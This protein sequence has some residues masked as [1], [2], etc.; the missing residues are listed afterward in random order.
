MPPPCAFGC[1]S[2]GYPGSCSRRLV[3]CVGWCR[4]VS[5]LAYWSPIFAEL[6]Y[7]PALVFPVVK[8]IEHDATTRFEVAVMLL[9]TFTL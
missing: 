7:L 4:L 9:S 6:N 2:G 3:R 1:T 8:L 5:A